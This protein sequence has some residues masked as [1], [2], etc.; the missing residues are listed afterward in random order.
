MLEAVFISDLHLHAGQPAISQRFQRLLKW[1]PAKT[2]SLYILGDF[3]HACCG[4][5]GLDAYSLKILEQLKTLTLQG[6]AIYFMPGNRD[7][8]LGARLIA[9]YGLFPLKDPSIIK[10]GEQSILLSHGD[11]YCTGDK[12]HQRL[13]RLTRNNIFPFIFKKL[14]LSFRQK[15]VGN[16]RKMSAENKE[17]SR[18]MMDTV[19]KDL[20]KAMQNS[21]TAMII[22]GHTHRPA[23]KVLKDKDRLYQQIILSDWDDNPWVLCYDISVGFYFDQKICAGD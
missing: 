1:L 4:E 9:K 7:F 22:H 2:R 11:R 12:A 10:L 13:M 15:L 5:D 6:M 17:K 23:Q 19:E 16:L 20:I 3:F 14:P 8:L 18:S 21:Q